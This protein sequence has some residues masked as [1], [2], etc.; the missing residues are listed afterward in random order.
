MLFD[1]KGHPIDYIYLDVNPAF[2]R[3][4]GTPNVTGKPATEVFPG[5]KEAYPELFEIYG[6]VSLTGTPETFDLNFKPSGRWLHIFV[7][8]P[9]K[10]HFVAV[11]EDVTEQKQALGDLQHMANIVEFS[12]DAIIG[13][14]LDGT[15]VSWNTGAEKMY[16]YSAR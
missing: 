14:N 7:Y 13:K 1:D 12:D 4:I 6:R 16:G 8:S 11:F 10:A 2:I 9:A 15:I 3:I 5:I